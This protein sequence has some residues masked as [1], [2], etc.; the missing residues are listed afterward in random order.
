MIL[1]A[2]GDILGSGSQPE[3]ELVVAFFADEEAGGGVGASWLVD[4]HPELFAGATEAISEVGGYSITVGGRARL[5]AADGRE[6]AHLGAARRPRRRRPRLAADPRQ[7][8]HEA[9][10]GHRAPRPHRVAAAPHRHHARAPRRDR[11]HARRRPRAG[12]ARR[13]R[14]RDRLGVGVHHRDAPHDHEPDGAR[15]RLQAQ[16]DPRPRGGARRHPHAARRRRTRCSP[17]SAR[18]SA[19]TSRSRSCTGTSASRAPRP[20]R[21]S[22]PSSGRSTAHDPGRRVFPYLLSGGTDN[23]SLCAARHRGLRVLAAAAA[24]RPRL[25][26]DVPRRRRARAARRTILR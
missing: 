12:R 20:A 3:R 15:R 2:L 4:Q 6:V 22:T 10:R 21:S 25:P 16:R 23:K 19:T 1:T 5:P 11:R 26:G 8:R 24:G 14:P 18:S 17:R 9:R 13:A 7:R